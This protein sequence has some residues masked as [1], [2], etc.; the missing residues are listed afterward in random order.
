MLDDRSYMRQP[1]ERR[2]MSATVAL[3]I[4]LSVIHILQLIVRLSQGR[5][6]E[7]Y[8]AL[9]PSAPAYAWI[10]QLFTYQVLHGDPLHLL[11]NIVGLYCVGRSVEESL[12]RNKFLMIFFGTGLAGGLF[13]IVC[14]LVLPKHFGMVP[15]VGASAGVCGLIAVF[16][17]LYWEMPITTFFAFIIPISMRAKFL[18]LFIGLFALICMLI[19]GSGVAHAA[20]L[21]GLL[22]GLGYMRFGVLAEERLRNWYHARPVPQPPRRHRD[23]ELVKTHSAKRSM[24]E[25]KK[26]EPVVAEELP[27]GEFI[28][29]EVDPILDKISAHGIQ[30]LTERERQIL[31]KAR[32]KMAKRS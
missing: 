14:D 19:P 30:S 1:P 2:Y 16:A 9:N 6:F 25:T 31:E 21:G 11:C 4:T 15:V 24:W 28:S 20:H 32:A 23:R 10:W 13:Q 3:I 18:V 7:S 26:A 27:P 8:L 17:S 22:A 29:R 5:T 12:G